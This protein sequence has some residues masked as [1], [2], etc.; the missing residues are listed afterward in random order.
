MAYMGKSHLTKA[1]EILA[2]H[3]YFCSIDWWSLGVIIYEMASAK[4]LILLIQRPF[5]AKTNEGLT[6][7]ILNDEIPLDPLSKISPDLKTLI[8]DFLVRD[9]SKRLGSKDTG[10]IENIKAHMFFTSLDWKAVSEKKFP[11]AFI[12]DVKNT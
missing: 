3:G 1:P 4:V 2:K 6:N 10:G 9:V 8:L 11:P 5:R 12:P 7:A